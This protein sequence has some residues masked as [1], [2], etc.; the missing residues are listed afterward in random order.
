MDQDDWVGSVVEG[1]VEYCGQPRDMGQIVVT[2]LSTFAEDVAWH[3]RNIQFPHVWSK[4][5]PET[6]R[7]SS[8]R[9]VSQQ[10][11]LRDLQKLE[12]RFCK[13][14]FNNA[15]D[16]GLEELVAPLWSLCSCWGLA[17][18]LPNED[19]ISGLRMQVTFSPRYVLVLWFPYSKDLPDFYDMFKHRLVAFISDLYR[20]C[21]SPYNIQRLKFDTA[22]SAY[23]LLK[24]RL[25][26]A[27]PRIDCRDESAFVEL[28]ANDSPPAVL[29]CL[30]QMSHDHSSY[31]K[32]AVWRHIQDLSDIAYLIRKAKFET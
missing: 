23:N 28:F 12:H 22:E 10:A 8:S 25:R 24:D 14:S 5:D 32:D 6:A 4:Y 16:I 21:L 1:V 31:N 13:L 11:W 27:E 2:Y 15:E 26:T 3:F 19:T 9:G 30:T 18:F 17:T 7:L 29:H 20:V